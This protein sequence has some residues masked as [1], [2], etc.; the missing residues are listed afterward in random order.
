VTRTTISLFQSTLRASRET[1]S[2]IC[3]YFPPLYFNP[4]SA[5]AERQY[6]RMKL[7]PHQEFQSTFRASRETDL[8]CVFQGPPEFQ[9]TLRASRE[10]CGFEGH[11][12]RVTISIHS[13]RKQRDAPQITI[14]YI[15]SISIHSPRKQ[16][17]VGCH[18]IGVD[19][20]DFNPLSAQ[21]ERPNTEPDIIPL[22]LFQSTLR[23][24]RET[25]LP[26]QAYTC[27]F[28]SIH[29]PRKQRDGYRA[30]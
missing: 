5:Q 16:R 4:L 25:R 28:I 8:S 14:P 19:A 17:D 10:T 3:H 13:P 11:G 27:I 21:A 26:E 30:G 7:F 6:V 20:M 22:I 9:S 15:K 23:A 29:S 18:L 12:Y 2:S 24:S 1:V